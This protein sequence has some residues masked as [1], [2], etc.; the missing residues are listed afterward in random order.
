MKF[1]RDWVIMILICGAVLFGW[2]PLARY[3]GWLPESGATAVQSAPV[4][5]VAG[6][7]HPVAVTPF[8]GSFKTPE[9]ANPAFKLPELPAVTM[10][11]EL[12]KV[13]IEPAR[14]IIKSI[15]LKK[16][17]MAK[18]GD[19]PGGNIILD[20]NRGLSTDLHEGAL[21]VIFSGTAVNNGVISSKL[22]D[23]I[24][25]L[26]R[27]FTVDGFPMIVRQE[28][29]LKNDYV[30]DYKVALFNPNPQNLK[31]AIFGVDGGDL[32]DWNKLSG[33]VQRSDSHTIGYYTTSNDYVGDDVADGALPNKGLATWEAISNKYFTT[34]LSSEKPFEFGSKMSNLEANKFLAFVSANFSNVEVAAHSSSEYNFK[35]YTGPKIISYLANFNPSTARLVHL[36]WGPIDY[37]ARFLL[38]V[39][40]FFKS[41]CHSYGWSII[42]LTVIVRILFWPITQKANASMKKMQLVQPK[43]QEI[44]EKFSAD[45]AQMNAKIMEL[46]RTEGVNPLGGCLPILLQIPVFFALYAALNG[47]VELRHVPF[48]WSPDLAGPDTVGHIFGLAI[49]PLAIMMTVLMVLQ[50]FMTP[51][52]MPKSQQR[53]MMIMPVVMLFILY[54]LPSG[55]TLYWTVSQI[56]SILQL[57]AQNKFGAGIV[58]PS[59]ATGK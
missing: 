36:S 35:Y 48:W 15:E 3:M 24:Y 30:I 11:N 51:S 5:P 31:L 25:T 28:W 17:Q 20:S 7:P 43:V 42:I 46:Y 59:A 57:V 10:E 14:G 37:L 12:V 33:D 22:T 26:E 44:R 8:A 49:N 27:K 4:Q 54:N 1:D 47:A 18:Q 16:Y 53:M 6:Q 19:T 9:Q 45:A 55:L 13:T 56:F 34:V 32:Q 52:T 38:T 39:L 58:K 23:N 21:G 29:T 2:T 41:I 50:Q 40:V